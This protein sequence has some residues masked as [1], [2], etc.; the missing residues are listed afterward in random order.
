MA[1]QPHD[2]VEVKPVRVLV[3]DDDPGLRR[4]LPKALAIHKFEVL[5]AA[6]V[7]EALYLFV[8]RPVDVVVTDIFMP[9][10]D[11]IQLIQEI[12]RHRPR[13]P[14]VAM[15]GGGPLRD[16]SALDVA[17]AQGAN[18]LLRKP[19]SVA[20]LV[21]SIRRVLDESATSG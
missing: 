20:D 19:F 12:R 4:F 8:S 16:M 13:F 1:D 17:A 5:V 9:D 11:G 18:A 6:S 21:A 14:I 2:T 3:V 15:T 7:V 10:E